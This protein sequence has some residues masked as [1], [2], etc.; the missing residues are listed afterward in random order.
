MILLISSFNNKNYN[1]IKLI[2]IVLVIFNN[3]IV[4]LIGI[5]PFLSVF[6]LFRNSN[7]TF[8]LLIY[9]LLILSQLFIIIIALLKNHII[10]FNFARIII[11]FYI[12]I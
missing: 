10:S 4:L 7:K 11:L 5:S 9:L 8:F 6:L 1:K 12:I 2:T 3:I